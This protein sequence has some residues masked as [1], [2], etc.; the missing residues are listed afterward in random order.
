MT[1]KKLIYLDNNATTM[2]APEVFEAMRPFFCER[3]GNPSS[4]HTFGGSVMAAVEQARTRVAGLIGADR[5]DR[6]GKHTEVIFTGCGTESDNTAILS[7]LRTC[8][9]KK[10]VVMSTVEHPAVLSLGK[11]LEQRGY[12][13][14]YV[15]VDAHGRLDMARYEEMIDADTA[16]VSIMWANNETGNI[17]PVEKCAEIAHRYG[18]LFHTDAV[19]AIGKIPCDLSSSQIDMLS[20]SGHKL[21]APKGVGMLY[22]RRGIHFH[23][24]L[25][26]GHQERG[27]R[28][29]TENVASI[30][31]LGKAAE[32]AMQTLEYENT[33]VR[34]LRDKLENNLCTRIPKTQILGDPENRLPNTALIGFEAIEGESILMRMDQLGICASSGSAC[35]TGSLEP[36]HVLRAMGVPYTMAHSAVRF[37]LSRYN[38]EDEIDFVIREMPAIISW[39][40][41]LSPFWKAE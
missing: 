18:A 26:G 8:P 20:L 21:H 35:T 28:A 37:S 13:V 1:E 24:R 2:V 3:Y 14:S 9:K 15:P 41:K 29:G 30:I 5:T 19:Q 6:H 32:M 38:T 34:A 11:E 31:G 36:S 4:I 10:K 12:P 33:R 17:Y 7:A 16:V 23:P 27:R 22:V 40:R 39:L 25:I